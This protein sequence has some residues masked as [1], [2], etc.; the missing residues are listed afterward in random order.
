MRSRIQNTVTLD[1]NA[2]LG[3]RRL[4]YPALSPF[5]SRDG[6]WVAKSGVRGIYGWPGV[7]FVWL[8]AAKPTKMISLLVQMGRNEHFLCC[9]G[10]LL[11]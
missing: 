5:F 3:G 2:A 1:S 11:K 8:A 6:L 10:V 7:A 4:N 9:A